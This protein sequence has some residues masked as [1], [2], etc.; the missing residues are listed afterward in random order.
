M[1]LL[2]TISALALA[3]GLFVSCFGEG[4]LI[5]PAL[6]VASLTASPESQ[7][8][9][10][11]GSV[12]ITFNIGVSLEGGAREDV[13]H[14][15]ASLS[16]EASGGTVS[17][18]SATTDESGKVTVTFTTPNPN[19]FDG[20][21]VKG[22]VIKLKGDKYT[23]EI[24]Q[25]GNL[26]NATA[27]ILPMDP[28][29]Q[30]PT[31]PSKEKV[32]PKI[33][34]VQEP[35][36]QED[37]KTVFV[38]RVTESEV[39]STKEDPLKDQTVTFVSDKEKGTFTE[40]AVTDEKGEA[41]CEYEPKDAENF[42]GA[43]VTAK[44][45]VEYSDGTVDVE[46]TTSIP[47]AE[48]PARPSKDKVKPKIVVVQEPAK[49]E[50]G[51]TVF[52]V[53]VTESEVGS[54][55]EDPLKDQT[56]TFVSDKEKGTFT[57]SAVTDE[58]G[59]AK[60]E[61]E[62]KDAENFPGADVTAKATVE[63][64]DGTVDVET[65]TSIPK[66]V[67]YAYNLSCLNSPQQID[68][69]GVAT[70]RFQLTGTADGEPISVQN[71]V[72]AFTA[73]GGTC[74]VS[75]IVDANGVATCVFTATDIDT[76]EQGTVVAS[77]QVR[78]RA[79]TAT[80]VVL[81]LPK[82]PI[83]EAKKL[84]E[85]TYVVQKGSDVTTAKFTQEE[86]RWYVG[87]G[88]T[89]KTKDAIKVIIMDEDPNNSTNAWGMMELPLG[90]A[91]KLQELDQEFMS[92]YPWFMAKFGTFR[93][94]K[95]V[96]VHAGDGTFGNLKKEVK[97]QIWLREVKGTKSYS[98]LYEFLFYF[99]FT[100]YSWDSTTQT[101]VLDGDYVIYGR[102]TVEQY[103]PQLDW[104]T[105]SAPTNWLQVGKS[106]TL[107]PDWTDG[108]DFDPSKVELVSQTKGSSSSED[109]DEGYFSWNASTRTLTAVKSSDNEKVYVKF[110]Y[111]GT[112]L[113]TI[114]QIATGPGWNYTS[115]SLSPKQFVMKKYGIQ[116]LTVDSYAPNSEAW[117]WAAVEI[118]PDT[119]PNEA[120]W[121]DSSNTGKLYNFNAK[122][123]KTY[124]LRFR[125]R[126]NYSVTSS[127]TIS[128]VSE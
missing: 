113:S 105:M 112:S 87:R 45:T 124:N 53:R 79:L 123:G 91:N 2:R 75:G 44:A 101:E 21:S 61:Y 51:K 67:Q 7:K 25:Q 3:A 34:V 114:T 5:D 23:G 76:F 121:L 26:A 63:Y 14:Y 37:G 110:K 56:V 80:G 103:N 24:F 115:F 39:G 68:E 107:E 36:K 16:F 10:A 73:F 28:E 100:N 108:A 74:A 99:A 38:V 4:D 95:E 82:E 15:T 6:R 40:S 9:N 93:T 52:V 8:M 125:I 35:A 20:G 13:R 83:N 22:T 128:V 102:A 126:S 42:P 30:Q 27:T 94:G 70:L 97:N 17:P 88:S 55:K 96:S 89:D 98:G 49:Q 64:S 57:E 72:L 90:V 54:T 127:V 11:S 59:E 43:D 116:Q 84:P 117:D 86:S 122:E 78:G 85:N 71:E 111:A 120:F 69:S 31:R 47:K 106:F 77:C 60:C 109:T 81:G 92:K 32:K 33:Y 62:P 119:N 29:P 12:S 58:K 65:T 18:T 46:T 104:F 41:K 1:K 50:D 48:P 118:D 66:A 19:S